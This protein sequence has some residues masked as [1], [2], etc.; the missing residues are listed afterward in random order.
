MSVGATSQS[1]S[2]DR[3]VTDVGSGL[4]GTRRTFLALLADPSVVT[5]VVE[6]RDRVAG[7]GSEYVAASREANGR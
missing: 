7:R 5:I 1:H 3:V 2:S 4:D 6:H